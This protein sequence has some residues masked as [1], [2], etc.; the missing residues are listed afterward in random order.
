MRKKSTFTSLVILLILFQL[1]AATTAGAQVFEKG[2]KVVD[3]GLEI[4][5]SGVVSIVPIFGDFE[6]GVTDDIGVG[7]R[8]RFWSKNSVNSFM[9]QPTGSYHFNRLLN[10]PVEQLDLFASVG[11]GYQRLSSHGISFSGFAFSPFAGGRYYFTERLGAVAKLGFDLNN[12]EGI[13][14][15]NFNFTIGVALKF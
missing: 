15:T 6:M 1:T 11:I 5:E 2:T 7:A 4:T 12:Y 10:L 13:S 8:V 14:S 3:A 9:L